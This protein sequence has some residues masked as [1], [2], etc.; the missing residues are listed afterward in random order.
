MRIKNSLWIVIPA[1]VVCLLGL[2]AC[3]TTNPEDSKLPWSEPKSWEGG[4]P[5]FDS[6]SGFGREY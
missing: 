2:N 1:V 6:G 3:S 4:P 5:G